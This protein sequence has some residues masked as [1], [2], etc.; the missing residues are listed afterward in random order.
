MQTNPGISIALLRQG[1][2]KM[3]KQQRSPS[4]EYTGIDPYRFASNARD[5]APRQGAAKKKR[6]GGVRGRALRTA[7]PSGL[8]PAPQGQG[9]S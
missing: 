7:K 1:L 9:M 3:A 4:M 5:M 6:G 8:G 2:L